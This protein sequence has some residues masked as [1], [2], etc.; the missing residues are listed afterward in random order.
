MKY[1]LSV[2]LFLSLMSCGGR[3]QAA[4]DSA[5]TIWEAA[6]ATE[7]G[8]SPAQTMPAIKKNA[9]AIIKSAGSTYAPAGIK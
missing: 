6:D 2:P 7:K 3:D 1:L 8:A 9:A 5:A 4:A